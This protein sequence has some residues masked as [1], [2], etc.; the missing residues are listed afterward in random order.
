MMDRWTLTFLDAVAEFVG[1]SWWI[2]F[3]LLAPCSD[4]WTLRAVSEGCELYSSSFFSLTQK[5]YQRLILCTQRPPHLLVFINRLPGCV[6]GFHR[7]AS[8]RFAG[9]SPSSDSVAL[10]SDTVSPRQLFDQRVDSKT[11]MTVYVMCW[12]LIPKKSLESA[13]RAAS[14]FPPLLFPIP[15]GLFLFE[16]PYYTYFVIFILHPRHQRSSLAGLSNQNTL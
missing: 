5:L 2:F 13:G 10:C 12:S 8:H 1:V 11:L 4:A 14:L 9:E 7:L 6:S 3:S 15:V 16:L